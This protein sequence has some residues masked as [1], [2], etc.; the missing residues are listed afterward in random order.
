MSYGRMSRFPS[1]N[2]GKI[3]AVVI[4]FIVIIV[5]MFE[6][7]VIVEAGHRGV[8]LYLGAVENRVLGEGLHFIVPFAEQVIQMEVRTQKIPS[9]ASVASND[10]QEVLTVIALNYWID[11]HEANRINKLLDVNYADRVVSSTI[12]ELVKASV[13]KFNTEELITKRQTAR[14][15]IAQDIENPHSSNNIQV[16]NVF[17]TDYNISDAFAFQFEQKVLAFQKVSN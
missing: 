5:V 7:V 13:A 3:A 1:Y 11:P 8:V 14:G 12:Q 9:W 4:T 2:I 6:S 10:L 15:I 16:K 17:T